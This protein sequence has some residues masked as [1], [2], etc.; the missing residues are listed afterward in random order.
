MLLKALGAPRRALRYSF[1]NSIDVIR[2][3]IAQNE[4]ESR[5]F[6][7]SLEISVTMDALAAFIRVTL[8]PE[9]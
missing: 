5:S 6:F 8:K 3:R 9:K 1:D 4:F 7:S 2:E